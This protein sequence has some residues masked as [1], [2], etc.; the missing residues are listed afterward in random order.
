MSSCFNLPDS[1][2]TTSCPKPRKK[3]TR[4]RKSCSVVVTR[5]V[6]LGLGLLSLS[7][8]AIAEVWK[9]SQK[10]KMQQVAKEEDGE[11]LDC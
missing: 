2:I 6:I 10:A 1:G 4:K 5:T 11:S 8:I 3:K 9:K 7:S